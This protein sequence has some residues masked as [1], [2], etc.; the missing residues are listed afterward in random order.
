MRLFCLAALVAAIT[1][2]PAARADEVGGSGFDVPQSQGDWLWGIEGLVRTPL[3]LSVD[4]GISF[5]NY[6]MKGRAT[7]DDRGEGGPVVSRTGTIEFEPEAFEG[8]F[9]FAGILGWWNCCVLFEPAIGFRYN[10]PFDNERTDDTPGVFDPNDSSEFARAEAEIKDGWDLMFGPQM[11][12]IIRDDIPVLGRYL[13]G[14]PMVLFPYV[15]VTRI[16][17]DAELQ[18]V[19]RG[20]GDDNAVI[21]RNFES[22]ELLVGFDLDIPLPGSHSN[23]THGLTFS[24]KWIEGNDDHD[25]GPFA[26][27]DIDGGTTVPPGSTNNCRG[28]PTPSDDQVCFSFADLDGWRIGLYYKVTWNDFEGFFKRNIFGPVD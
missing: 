16:D 19:E 18:F 6:E 8:G 3:D 2:T 20:G 17:W 1:F 21:D 23:F 12:W 28:G 11:T 14:L 13:G 7:H 25:L 5:R 10:S 4:A 22:D 15:G 26:R 9:R 24:F 27:D